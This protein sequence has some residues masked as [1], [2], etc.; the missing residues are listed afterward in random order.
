[1]L[2]GRGLTLCVRNRALIYGVDLTAQA[3]EV[4]AILGPNGSGKTTLLR[5]LSGERAA[6]GAV[7][8]NGQDMARLSVGTLAT[9]RAV[10]P[11]AA[12][13]AFPFTVREVVALGLIGRRATLPSA[14][15]LV[16][17]ALARV[18]MD[19]H[20]GALVQHLSGGEA[21]RVQ[22]A[23]TLLQVWEPVEAGRPRWLMLDEPVA[24]LDLRQQL[25]VL[26]LARRFAAEGGGVVA[27]MHDLNLTAMVADRVIL[28]K[29]GRKLAEGPPCEVLTDA[30]LAELY[31]L[32]LRV[33]VVPERGA[34]VLPQAMDPAWW[35]GAPA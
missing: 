25:A 12:T 26:H 5:V 14:A 6:E 30:L 2:V 9:M 3:G 23:R 21:Q 29:R 31:D 35:G 13:L 4:T 11:Q 24:A 7:H 10:L 19:H 17:Q 27:V 1:M 15:S 28:M 20:A 34:F 22:L 18:G 16:D 32:P 8:L 33:G